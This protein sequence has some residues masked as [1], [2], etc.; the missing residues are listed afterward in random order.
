MGSQTVGQIGHYENF[1][2]YP[3]SKNTRRV[4]FHGKRTEKELLYFKIKDLIGTGITSTNE[5]ALH[6][7]KSTRQTRRYLKAM[8]RLRMVKLY[9]KTGRIIKEMIYQLTKEI[10]WYGP[11]WMAVPIR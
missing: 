1:C 7:G 8:A 3:F 10:L 6:L 2:K 4:R 9:V 11:T 5:L